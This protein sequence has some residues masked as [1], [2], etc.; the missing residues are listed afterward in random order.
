MPHRQQT[1]TRC[2]LATRKGRFSFL[3]P[4]QLHF[5]GFS[6]SQSKEVNQ[7]RCARLFFVFVNSLRHSFDYHPEIAAGRWNVLFRGER[8]T[9]FIDFFLLCSPAIS[10]VVIYS[11]YEAEICRSDMELISAEITK[12]MRS[13]RKHLLT[14]CLTRSVDM[15]VD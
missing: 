12:L 1:H 2:G 13:A 15:E 5:S 11:V 10:T 14:K 7:S 3:R 4:T 8:N 9:I 6:P